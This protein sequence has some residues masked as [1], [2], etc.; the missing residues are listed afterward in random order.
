MYC[1]AI[2]SVFALLLNSSGRSAAAIIFFRPAFR[3]APASLAFRWL[4]R[5]R[6]ALIAAVFLLAGAAAARAGQIIYVRSE[7]VPGGDGSTWA[8]AYASLQDAIAASTPSGSN[9]V[10]FWLKTGVYKPTTG[11][12][13]TLAFVPKSYTTIR[14]GFAGTETDPSQ[15]VPAAAATAF[16]VLSGDIGAAQ[17]DTVT[18]GTNVNDLADFN[19]DSTQA[20]AQD[21]SYNVLRLVDSTA[22]ALDE[23]VVA[24]GCASV[25][26]DVVSTGIVETM[27][28]PTGDTGL[29]F[30]QDLDNR[31]T[32]GG[33][34]VS[35][36]DLIIT[37][38]WF[39]GNFSRGIGGGVVMRGGSL[40]LQN[41]Q[42]VRNVSGYGGGGL[43][44]QAVGFGTSTYQ[45]FYQNE[46]YGNSSAF[47]GGGL[48][49]QGA[50]DNQTVKAYEGTALLSMSALTASDSGVAPA[51]THT[52]P[53]IQY[54]QAQALSDAKKVAKS[55][56]TVVQADEGEGLSKLSLLPEGDIGDAI[57]GAYAVVCI[58]EA[59]VDLAVQFAEFL[60]VPTD[61]PFIVGWTSFATAFNEY[62][63]PVGL[64]ETIYNFF[65]NFDAPS[66][67]E[68]ATD[69]REKDYANNQ[70]PGDPITLG[71]NRFDLN[72]ALGFGG[73]AAV[74]QANVTFNQS[75]FTSNTADYGGGGA[76]IFI[77]NNVDIENSAFVGN[78]SAYGHSAFMGGFRTINRLMN[79]SFVGNY[80]G[81]ASGDAV[82][83]DAGADISL[84]NDALWNN[85]NGDKTSAANPNRFGGA[86]LWA[87]RQADLDANAL[88]AYNT[89]GDSHGLFTG[90]LD[91]QYCDVQSLNRLTL[92]TPDFFGGD[93]EVNIDV[94][95]RDVGS[96]RPNV[97]E[98]IRVTR[99]NFSKDPM[100]YLNI[101]PQLASPVINAGSPYAYLDNGDENDIVNN[102]RLDGFID[103]GA[104]ESG[105]LLPSG[106]TAYVNAAAI[107]SGTGFTWATAFKTLPEALAAPLSP[108]SSIWVAQ[109]TYYPTAGADRTATMHLTEGVALIGSLPVGATSIDQSNFALYPSIISGAI[110]APGT[111]ANNSYVLLR[112]TDFVNTPDDVA[113]LPRVI[114]G[115]RFT[116]ANSNE[117]AVHLAVPVTIQNCTFDTNGGAR[118]LWIEDPGVFGSNRTTQI[119]DSAFTNNA[120]GALEYDANQV[121]LIRCN[122]YNNTAPSG[123]A[124][125]QEPSYTINGTLELERCILAFNTATAGRG[126]AV[127]TNVP[128]LQIAQTDIVDNTATPAAG[129]TSTNG[130]AGFWWDASEDGNYNGAWLTVNSIFYNNTM[131]GMASP[132]PLEFQQF[133][134]AYAIP[135]Y[136]PVWANR[137]FKANDLQG[138][139]TL[140]V[141]NG[142][143][144]NLDFIPFFTNAP[145]DNFALLSNSPLINEGTAYTSGSDATT[146]IYGTAPDIGAVE[147][148]VTT[149][150]LQPI[151]LTVPKPTTA[152][153]TF[154]FTFTPSGSPAPTVFTWQ[155]E[156]ANSGLWL[157]VANDAYDSGATTATLTVTNPPASWDGSLYRLV[158]GSGGSA[159]Y[160]TTQTLSVQPSIIYVKTVTSGNGDGSTWVN[161]MALP[162][163]LQA[164][165]P[166]TNLWVQSGTYVLAVDFGPVVVPP[167]VRIYG[168][169]NGTETTFLQRPASGSVA[170]TAIGS[171]LGPTRL[172]ITGTATW[173]PD[174]SPIPTI[175]D[176]V[177]IIPSAVTPYQPA[178]VA[179][180]ANTLFNNVAFT[181]QITD[182]LVHTGQA[183][184]TNSQFTGA[185][186]PDF[187]GAIPEAALD[188]NAAAVQI[189]GCRFASNPAGAVQGESAAISVADSVFTANQN[190][191][192]GAIVSGGAAGSLNVQRC[193]FF[194]NSAGVSGGAISVGNPSA[195]SIAN[196]VFGRNT[197]SGGSG[198]AVYTS[199]G[200]GTVS[201]LYSTLADN[202]ALYGAAVDAGGPVALIDSIAW[203]NV[204]TSAGANGPAVSGSITNTNSTV[205]GFSGAV[206]PIF[207]PNSAV[208]A[209]SA[210]SPLL[211]TGDVGTTQSGTTD[212]SGNPRHYAGGAADPGASEF[213]GTAGTPVYLTTEPA[214]ASL[215][216][217]TGATFSVA[218]NVGS[219]TGAG[220]F[221]WQYWNGSAWVEA[222]G[223]AGAVVTPGANSSVLSIASV[224]SAMNGLQF[225]ATA[226]GVG[227]V[228]YATLTVIPRKVIYVVSGN[229]A[230]DDGR[231]WATAWP[232]LG[233]AFYYADATTDIWVKGGT[234][235]VQ[236]DQTPFPA[237]AHIYVGFAG[238][239]TSVDQRNPDLYPAYKVWQDG[240]SEIAIIPTGAN[241]MPS[242]P[243]LP[244]M[245]VSNSFP[246]SETVIVG[247]AAGFGC[248]AEGSSPSSNPLTW[249]YLAGSTWLPISNLSSWTVSQVGVTSTL[250]NP[251]VQL[252]DTGLT[253]RAV[254]AGDDE[255]SFPA[256]LTVQA[257]PIRYV[258]GAASP[259][260]DGTTWLRAFQTIGA[261]IAA[262]TANTDI[263]IAG[264]DYPLSGLTPLAGTRFYVGFT[265]TETSAAEA[266]PGAHP[267][268]VI[269]AASYLALVPD[270]N[271]A[272]PSLAPQIAVAPINAAPYVAK[273]IAFSAQS[274]GL[275]VGAL[276]WDYF[277]G[278]AW[279]SVSG[280]SGWSVTQVG[281]VSTLTNSAVP[282]SQSGLQFHAAVPGSTE[283]SFTA[284]LTVKPRV[285]LYVNL[286]VGASGDGTSWSNA[287]KTIGEALAVAD[288]GTDIWIVGG[289]YGVQSLTLV[290]GANLIGGFAGGENNVNQ[291]SLTANPV[292]L[293]GFGS[294]VPLAAVIAGGL[295]YNLASPP[296]ALPLNINQPGQISIT[297]SSWSSATLT[298]QYFDGS[299]WQPITS[300]AGWSV[301]TNGSIS[302]IVNASVPSSQNGT[303][304][305]VSVDGT[306]EISSVIALPVA[307]RTTLFV[308]GAVGNSGAGTAWTSAY[309][310]LAEAVAHAGSGTDIWIAQGTYDESTHDL[311]AGARVYGGFASGDASLAVRSP[312]TH[313]V[314]LR[315]SSGDGIWSLE[316]SGGNSDLI[317]GIDGVTIDG[318]A[319]ATPAVE[320]ADGTAVFNGVTFSNNTCALSTSGSAVVTL[321]ACSFTAN[322]T[323]LLIASGPTVT[324]TGGTF[325]GG[326]TAIQSAS[327]AALLVS[328]STFTNQTGTA[329]QTA[330]G[331]GL[332][333]S[334]FTGAPSAMVVTGTGTVLT[335]IL[336]TSFANQTSFAV[337]SAAPVAIT[338]GTFSGSPL[339]LNL[340]GGAATS[341]IA[342]S[343]FNHNADAVHSPA[344]LAVSNTVFD[345]NANGL[346]LS[347]VGAVTTV[348]GGTFSNQTAAG[349]QSADAIQVSGGAAFT[350][351][352][353]GLLLTGAASA[354]AVAG[355]TF[356]HNTTGIAAPNGL[357]VTGGTFG[358]DTTG[359]A[360]S[361]GSLAS[362]VTG[363]AFTGETGTAITSTALLTLGTDTFTNCATAVATIAGVTLTNDSISGGATGLAIA[364]A[365][366]PAT[367][368]ISGSTFSGL[369]VA[370]I[371]SVDTLALTN[372]AFTG[373]A[374]GVSVTGGGITS[375]T[376]ATV[377][378]GVAGLSVAYPAGLTLAGSLFTGNSGTGVSVAQQ[379]AGGHD[380]SV[381]TTRFLNNTGLLFTQALRA[382][383][384]NRCTITG[385]T[386]ATGPLIAGPATA[387]F[388]NTLL[389]HNITTNQAPLATAT[390]SGAI[391]IASCTIADNF[392]GTETGVAASSFSVSITQSIL[393]GNRSSNS[394]SSIEDMQEPADGDATVTQSVIEDI[395]S[396]QRLQSA[397]QDSSADPLFIN[398]P[399]N[400]YA[401]NAFSAAIDAGGATFSGN[402]LDLAGNPR[403]Q[404]T[405]IDL[406]AL[407]SPYTRA[408]SPLS[409]ILSVASPTLVVGDHATLSVGFTA[410]GG[411]AI[412]WQVNTGSGWSDL[413][414]NASETSSYDG[415][416]LSLLLTGSLAINGRQYRGVI[417][418]NGTD[419]YFTAPS[420]LTVTGP[421]IIYV[422]AAATGANNGT[423]WTDAYTSLAAALAAAPTFANVNVAAGTYAA[424]SGGSWALGNNQQLLGSFTAGTANRD[425]ANTPTI[426]ISAGPPGTSVIL[427][428]NGSVAAGTLVDG[429]TF[430]QAGIGLQLASA[431]LTVRNCRFQGL[432]TGISSN[433]TSGSKQLIVDS[434]SFTGQTA[435]AIRQI[436]SNTQLQV[437]NST[438]TGNTTANGSG[439]GGGGGAIELGNLSGETGMSLV[440]VGSTFS[441]NSATAQAGGA[442]NLG[443]FGMTATITGC[444][445]TG[446][447]T[448]QIGG[449]I[450]Q[451]GSGT[452][453]VRDTLLAGN[454]AA[455]GGAAI[456][457]ESPVA[458][459]Y[460]TVAGNTVTATSTT[461]GAVQTSGG[462]TVFDSILWG[463]TCGTVTAESAQFSASGGTP[464]FGASI[465]QS[466][467]TA[468]GPQ[469]LPFDPRFLDAAGG[470]YRLAADSPALGLGR[471]AD[472]VTSETDLLGVTRPAGAAPDLGAYE[473]TGVAAAT[474]TDLLAALSAPAP[475]NAGTSLLLKAPLP[476]GYTGAWQYY[477]GSA[478]ITITNSLPGAT[479][480][481]VFNTSLLSQSQ[482]TLT[483]ILPALNGTAL[484]YTL[485]N[486]T[487]TYIA[488]VGSL[489]I[490]PFSGL[491]VDASRAVSGDG[492]SWATAFN[493]LATG[494]AAV[495][496]AHRILYVAQGTYSGPFT[497]PMNVTM[498]GGFPAGGGDFAAR[499]PGAY[500]TILEGLAAD[501]VTRANPVVHLTFSSTGYIPADVDGFVVENGQTGL[502]ADSQA[503]P[504]L[505]NLVVRGNTATGLVLTNSMAKVQDSL[506]ENNTGV[507]GGAICAQSGGA[508]T[509]DRVTVRGNT[510]SSLG[511]GL[512]L[513]DSSVLRDVLITGNVA[514][515]GGGVCALLGPQLLQ[516]TIAGNRARLSPAIYTANSVVALG[517]SIVWGNRATQGTVN[518]QFGAGFGGTA[519]TF[520][521]VDAEQAPTTAGVFSYDPLFVFPVDPA[522]APVTTGDYQLRVVSSAIDAGSNTLASGLTLDVAG[523]PRFV[524]PVDL[525]AYESATTGVAPLAVTTSP[526][527]VS[528]RTGAP[529][530]FTVAA[531][532]GVS[533]AWQYA[534][535]NGGAWVS[536]DGVAGFSGA[537]TNTLTVTSAAVALNGYGFRALVTGTDGSVLT[538]GAA[539]LTVFS[540]QFYVNSGRSGTDPGDGLTWATA[541]RSLDTALAAAPADAQGTAYW[542]AA[543]TYVPATAFAVRSGLLLYGG[544]AGGE[545]TLA[546]RNPAANVTALAGA[547]GQPDVILIST[548]TG[549]ILSARLD[550]LTVENSTGTG[551]NVQT[552]VSVDVEGVK[553]TGLSMVLNSF[554]GGTLN[555]YHCEFRGNG[556]GSNNFLFDVY[557]GSVLIENSLFA[558]NDGSSH[559]L[560]YFGA[561]TVSVIRQTTFAD[562]LSDAAAVYYDNTSNQT[563]NCVFWGN[564]AGG[565]ATSV[566]GSA[567]PYIMAGNDFE[568]LSFIPSLSPVSFTGNI[569][570]DPKFAAPIAAS[571]APF[572]GGTFTLGGTSLAI[573]AGLNTQTSSSNLDLAGNPR[574]VGL[575]V[576]PGAYEYQGNDVYA[577]TTQPAAA[578]FSATLPVTFTV[579]ASHPATYTWQVS[580]DGTNFT[581]IAGATAATLSVPAGSGLPGYSYRA[582]VQFTTGPLLTSNAAP[583]TSGT[584]LATAGSSAGF[585]TPGQFSAT[586]TEAVTA[587]QW[588]VSVNGGDY[589]NV[590][591]GT[592]ATLQVLGNASFSNRNYRVS[593]TLA[594]GTVAT[595]NSIAFTYT[596]VVPVSAS[597]SSPGFSLTGGVLSASVNDGSVAVFPQFGGRLTI[598]SGSLTPGVNAGNVSFTTSRP[599]AAGSRVWV[600][601]TSALLRAD[602]IGARPQVWE[603]RVPTVSGIGAF[604]A[605]SALSPNQATTLAAGDVDGDGTIDLIV[606]DTTGLRVWR[607]NGLGKFTADAAAFGV[608]GARAIALG[609]L[610][611]GSALDAVVVTAAGEVQIW[612]NNGA[613]VF[614]LAQSLGL[615]AARA[616]ALGDLDADGDLDLF[617]ATAGGNRVYFNNGAGGFTFGSA[618]D[619]V[620]GTSV[621]LGDLNNDGSLDAVVTSSLGAT[622]WANNGSGGFSPV[623]FTASPED[624]VA[625]ADLDNDGLL[626][627]ILTLANQPAQ[628]L[629]NTGSFEFTVLADAPGGGAATLAA[630]DIDGDGR[631]DLVLTGATGSTSA[632]LTSS[633]PTST[634]VPDQPIIHLTAEASLAD[635]DGD[636]ALDLI[637]ID[638]NGHA[639]VSLYR[640]TPTKLQENGAAALASAGFTPAPTTV[641][642]ITLPTSGVLLNGGV[643]V[644]A[645]SSMTLAA[646][647]ALTYQPAANFVGVDSFTWSATSGGA[648]RTYGILTQLV[649][650]VPVANPDSIAVGQ[651][652]TATV[653]TGGATS[654]LAND[655][656]GDANTVL[657][658]ALVTPPAHGTVT[659]NAD[660]T[661]SYVQDNTAAATDSFVYSATNQTSGLS[662]TAT[663][664]IA[665]TRHN[666]A[667][668]AIAL[669]P[670]GSPPYTGQPAGEPVATLSAFDPDPA[671]A[672]LLVF[673]LVPG[674]GSDDNASFAI[675]GTSL[676]TNAIIDFSMGLTRSIRIRVTDTLG[677]FAEQSFTVSFTQAP[678]AAAATVTTAEDAP[679]AIVLSGAGGASALTYS[680]TAAPSHGTLALST[681]APAPNSFV[682]TPALHYHGTDSFAYQVADSSLSS[683][684][685]TITLNITHVAYPPTLAAIAPV[686][687]NENGSA[688]FT[689][690][691][692]DLDNNP[693]TYALVGTA[694]FGTVQFNGAVVTYTPN[695][696]AY[697]TETLTFTTNDGFNTSAPL[698][699]VIN[700]THVNQAPV[701]AAIA[702]R[703][704]TRNTTDTYTPTL[705]DVDGNPIT[706][707]VGTAAQ[708]GTVTVS[709]NVVTYVPTA[710]YTG[711]DSY[712]LIA[713]ASS[714]DSVPLTVSVNVVALAPE[715]VTSL[716]YRGLYEYTDIPAAQSGDWT[717]V[718]PANI[719]TPV[720]GAVVFD[721]TRLLYT[722]NGDAATGDSYT[723][724][725]T[726]SADTI[727][728]IAVA[729]TI[730]DRVISVTSTADAGANTLR[731]ALATVARFSNDTLTPAHTASPDWN[732]SINTGTNPATSFIKTTTYYTPPAPAPLDDSTP[733]DFSSA[734]NIAGIVTIDAGA[735]PGFVLSIQQG[736]QYAR[737]FVVPA[738]A[739]LTLKNMKVLNGRAN[740]D[741]FRDSAGGAVLNYGIFVANNVTFEGGQANLGAA[742]Y[743]NG[744]TVSLTDCAF[745]ANQVL[746]WN[747][748]TG[749]VVASRNGSLA[750]AGDSFADSTSPEL[751]VVGDGALATVNVSASTVGSFVLATANGGTLATTGLPR[752]V[753]DSV[754]YP[755]GQ[756]LTINLATLEANDLGTPAVSVAVDGISA[757]GVT[758]TRTGNS[759]AYQAPIGVTG[760]DSFSYT[761]TDAGGLT[762]T[763]TVN[764]TFV[765]PAA[766]PH[767]NSDT[768]TAYRGLSSQINVL[769]ND[770]D[771]T[772]QTLTITA[773]SAPAHGSAQIIANGTLIL[774]TENDTP[775]NQSATTDAFTY[776]VSNSQYT[777][778][779]VPVTVAINDRV[780]IAS[781]GADAGAGT[782]RDALAVVNGY[783]NTTLAPAHTTAPD[784][785]IQI[786]TSDSHWDTTSNDGA[787]YPDNLSAYRIKATSHITIDGS[788]SPNFELESQP[789]P[790]PNMNPVRNFVVE[791]G[792]SLTLKNFRLIGSGFGYNQS[793]SS[794][795]S[796][797]NYGTF[798]GD[799]V[800]FENQTAQLG[801]AILNDGG[802][803]SLIDCSFSGNT[804]LYSGIA[805][806]G[807]VT[808]RNGSL[809]LTGD[810]FADQYANPELY[811][812]N[813][814]GA[815]SL[816]TSDGLLPSYS[817]DGSVS[818]TGTANAANDT[819]NWQPGASLTIPVAT[820]LANDTGNSL[821]VVSVDAASSQGAAVA[822]SGGFVTYTPVSAISGDDTFNYA[823]QDI[824]GLTSTATVTVHIA[825]APVIAIVAR[826]GGGVTLNLTGQ[827]NTSHAISFSTDLL[828][829]SPLTTVATDGAGAASIDDATVRAFGVA[830]FYRAAAALTS[831]PVGSLRLRLLA[832]SDTVVSLPLLPSP[833]SE[834]AV[835]SVYGPDSQVSLVNSLPGLP[836]GGAYLLMMTGA[837]EGGVLPVSSGGSATVTVN[838]GPFDL[839]TVKTEQADGAGQGDVASL[840]PYWT[841]DT[842][843]PAGGKLNVTTSLQSI[844]SQVL[845]Y[846]SGVAGINLSPSAKYFYY[847]GDGSYSAG[848]YNAANMSPAGSTQIPPNQYFIVRQPVGSADTEVLVTGAVQLA[849]A[850]VPLA[851]LAA[852][853]KQDNLVALPIP[854]PVT[855]GT[856]QLTESGAFT[857]TTSLGLVKDE[858]LV[859]NNQQVGQNK[860]A[861]AVYF[862]F[863]G[864]ASYAAGWYRYGDMSAVVP[865]VILN[866]GEGFVIRKAATAS[867]QNFPWTLLPSY[868]Q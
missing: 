815:A 147:S 774:Y 740:S 236:L 18:A 395:T 130:G 858:L 489:T 96:D 291:A 853:Q 149:A 90:I 784:W 24:G 472:L 519:F 309:K 369:T 170:P 65:E 696:N 105:G 759:L 674:N 720:H 156:R 698:S 106:L 35:N 136:F 631:I 867:A 426:L 450:N 410:G 651:G 466:L 423:S 228:S 99:G 555:F 798:T 38:C 341:T 108:G 547:A 189:T 244:A 788:S 804:V 363:T 486:G 384:F 113:T 157:T 300:L 440:V 506:F 79:D 600:T 794:G 533:I 734:F 834:S 656:D 159:S 281:T 526:V 257:R 455:T 544:F 451:Y 145:T 761:V 379:T 239:E 845:M 649:P 860:S 765:L 120:A 825:V 763:A 268:R 175:F 237:G 254:F 802:T 324:L 210:D 425:S 190:S 495:D 245:N 138:L 855:L 539:T 823:I 3:F 25:T 222:S 762:S 214:D 534:A 103:V 14:G 739:S 659:V 150:G 329:I 717:G 182:V 782:I 576:D 827:A 560:V 416:T 732:V 388:E 399:A 824:N 339:G 43:C 119:V 695:V 196:S 367:S 569:S 185:S 703:T 387:T 211:N 572:T 554:E 810:T 131:A 122:F 610:R 620:A 200:A 616:V 373:C 545:T 577:I 686:T 822:L 428:A 355:A 549:I 787:G 415:H 861:S 667:P 34:F 243:E 863:A 503:S 304:I 152:G 841:L 771:D 754:N 308:N 548:Y 795:G 283:V 424:P 629:H 644:T 286:N 109:G 568:N 273:P 319:A 338:T 772:N 226:A 575:D 722:H 238:N 809:S 530:T 550:G 504:T 614:T 362:T 101:F 723:Y 2:A 434:C 457:S 710:G 475:A 50:T 412:R 128:N 165:A 247:Q 599:V 602:G 557:G 679:V 316:L 158:Y 865:S 102:R 747:G 375:I 376:G 364:A 618:F 249:Q 378:N 445:F 729:I 306:S 57:G 792:A 622:I 315:N 347:A 81:T 683:A 730:G 337:Q 398:A 716:V 843:F 598:A 468:A 601:T 311:A 141:L 366:S 142:A 385:N 72:Y 39:V 403:V 479:S 634:V 181:S 676:Q 700:V 594:D 868:L 70:N 293:Q 692:A 161:A 726:N 1:F 250:S 643:P 688:T 675:N 750:L 20:N 372:D 561:P 470:D 187:V 537:V 711:A 118:A 541:F 517:N 492:T 298:W 471:L 174:G 262:A 648:A 591:G 66:F 633:G 56:K 192:G 733:N 615:A 456:D 58:A 126:G 171:D 461:G 88:A 582:L 405:A 528:A 104:V 737:N 206:A 538:S 469:L 854:L 612:T 837:L 77:Y 63:T 505:S 310:T 513:Q 592:S 498:Y 173:A 195:S 42:F 223:L 638:S 713:S 203:D 345:S 521:H 393:W 801:A 62:A 84:I 107:S 491:Y 93:P 429:F 312:A 133:D 69:L 435:S 668:S 474:P 642:L 811:V 256:T 821:S 748:V 791:A 112:G 61:S 626:D 323:G 481:S 793:F 116:A 767:G 609:S 148:T 32:G 862:Y 431:S 797:L 94:Y 162:D 60:G 490:L 803:A 186:N 508:N 36:C 267:V 382:V 516:V 154:I 552:G 422:N 125:R 807:I 275:A 302:S 389:A 573:D 728:T 407:E 820:L 340:T 488:A 408:A 828:N 91:V 500:P 607:N 301:Q 287:F 95:G 646:A 381:A 204:A 89:A 671:D 699:V 205:Q 17:P 208:Y 839:T 285:T 719:S 529:A 736:V 418:E 202:T 463:N 313:P 460:S 819:V 255:L 527:G 343:N 33:A 199:N 370:G 219:S 37:S 55:V 844:Q 790:F 264:G 866:P 299:L 234:Y 778:A 383:V 31:V 531:T 178:I 391:Q 235:D 409:V 484:R 252:S 446:N 334:T 665:I 476:S 741:G 522:T 53:K 260:G 183:A 812:E 786:V 604:A 67:E 73:G 758:I 397:L 570:A 458:L 838:S 764:L 836:A 769:A 494:L 473:F 303:P 662:A 775:A 328:G 314:I 401:L 512:Y 670:T 396:A 753:N 439:N 272:L 68:R 611:G 229:N 307:G 605:P 650:T 438:F 454:L 672:G 259:S 230:G 589:A 645:G 628:I 682:Y 832:G 641:Y 632:W 188:L 499:N 402:T 707:R 144:G 52:D 232:D 357:T 578:I 749:S 179:E 708:H 483:G 635:L 859:F 134:T 269:A 681:T 335:E 704:V 146:I 233:T 78:Q 603:Y 502:L 278:S 114:R 441:G 477:N 240:N 579:V 543:G 346:V 280:L 637:G 851:T 459:V 779:N 639:V 766:P 320:L 630:G 290:P 419:I 330:P 386:V 625:I 514:D 465:V 636:G 197:A 110:G 756:I 705:I 590:S 184:F 444:T 680:I 380:S 850:R 270:A 718:A 849:S 191:F 586:A 464:N 8:R 76:A 344:G 564:R 348:T 140:A 852:N 627:V 123:A 657:V 207:D 279:V 30:Q 331:T 420:L 773:V 595:S 139:N 212:V 608:A 487:T 566:F 406:G 414:S 404:S 436:G 818:L 800:T 655:I 80:A 296:R 359:I 22:I 814:G 510:A 40:K 4:S 746:P 85:V 433:S 523:Q 752:A 336:N 558:G 808:S 617:V 666:T 9:P 27:L 218:G 653:L 714:L 349:I 462:L 288:Q 48:L 371:S 540:T 224:T 567:R 751:S 411:Y 374:L 15:R 297:R 712:T 111:T 829:W 193:Q 647:A 553:F 669:N 318:Q 117:A 532:G 59:T 509:F 725:L 180:G 684:S 448:S 593:A 536:L 153:R 831:D 322:A 274:T 361:G 326:G 201:I 563:Y 596:D 321:N 100:F 155:V 135:S 261:A 217:E 432:V 115:F 574:Q 687:I 805:T 231:S 660:G 817:F 744:G 658:A 253:V 694:A 697:G 780:L 271:A 799:N 864:N 738:G 701:I 613:G 5:A 121:D 652:G 663:V 92:G 702:P 16:T 430:Q 556:G 11:T 480:A 496:A 164:A 830:R 176:G 443:D 71:Q 98:G 276:A 258:N 172:T 151:V 6:I 333:S 213:Q 447:S 833:L 721:G 294:T 623:Y 661:F 507:N 524:G 770:T 580:V 246:T 45:A 673:T 305:R 581:A 51:A 755:V 520:D 777:T 565:A 129:D 535:P 840:V 587:W 327:G 282:Q 768:A 75:Y 856:S 783:L 835:D 216:A 377:Q 525:G 400:N 354:S 606:A 242:L 621:A 292:V 10:E 735:S 394:T 12:D 745:S 562:N 518:V 654:V 724:T 785:T 215:L 360:L 160:S 124:V 417:S 353:T 706:L 19:F 478:W 421:A 664:T 166:Y 727:R 127:Q 241:A 177:S 515:T 551:V 546:A 248:A 47:L 41:T 846:N 132:P 691:G 742:I 583:I 86:D 731:T 168:G 351:N 392:T 54:N 365:A 21:N 743:N 209:L 83:A 442:I 427:A 198:G 167:G 251:A 437:S 453:T 325:T 46:F 74:F 221:D 588:Q 352:Q 789:P 97:G 449:A 757:Q 143:D 49:I 137:I 776:S 485:N 584:V 559:G 23:I 284:A 225:R 624:K 571:S 26:E 689:L 64:A 413:T 87:T 390:G 482:L 266:N 263:W 848:W 368:T 847:A 678:T 163:A 690:V 813:T 760:G 857:P 13:R 693:L 82:G 332:E 467:Q 826:S 497:L 816:N 452:L 358:T 44:L 715:N 677:A 709:S 227:A 29:G 796:V 194:N 317:S 169:F 350:D 493:S 542:I 342:S 28:T 597:A 685:A 501:G 511:G 277:N 640:T 220:S 842:L 781:S 356:T 265:G 295:Q 7:A 585:A 289:S 806:A 619:S